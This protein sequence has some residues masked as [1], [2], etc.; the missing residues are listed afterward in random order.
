[1]VHGPVLLPTAPWA[2]SQGSGCGARVEPDR[3][4]HDPGSC[5]RAAFSLTPDL[6]VRHPGH[7]GRLSRVIFRT[8]SSTKAI[9]SGQLSTRCP[10]GG[11]GIEPRGDAS[12]AAAA[13]VTTTT[14]VM[15]GF[16]RGIV[17]PLFK[18]S[19]RTLMTRAVPYRVPGSAVHSTRLS[20]Q[21]RFVHSTTFYRRKNITAKT[22]RGQEELPTIAGSICC[23]PRVNSAQRR[24]AAA[25]YRA[26]L[27]FTAPF[28]QL[29]RCIHTLYITVECLKFHMSICFILRTIFERNSWSHPRCAA[30][31]VVVEANAVCSSHS[32]R[33]LFLKHTCA[34]SN[35][36][37]K[38]LLHGDYIKAANTG[39]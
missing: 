32:P 30:L 28:A 14:P 17:V 18:I 39:P 22:P 27:S 3:S 10:A 31:V 13:L 37:S 21:I 34:F 36:T 25:L 24:R 1:M 16:A 8:Q 23:G 7:A 29:L 35:V 9:G 2:A 11:P 19:R 15:D 20:D 12:S 38:Q 33:V 4:E 26:T 6:L 5:G